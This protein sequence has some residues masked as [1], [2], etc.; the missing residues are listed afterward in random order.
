MQCMTLDGYDDFFDLA[1]RFLL[2]VLL[3]HF[4]LRLLK[5]LPPNPPSPQQVCV[6]GILQTLLFLYSSS[7]RLIPWHCYWF[8]ATLVIDPFATTYCKDINLFIMIEDIL[9]IGFQYVHIVACGNYFNDVT[10]CELVLDCDALLYNV[11]FLSIQCFKL[12]LA[13]FPLSWCKIVSYKWAS[14]IVTDMTT[15]IIKFWSIQAIG[16]SACLGH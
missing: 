9:E 4:L 14:S 2:V 5:H 1:L 15:G 16:T 12:Q 11:K 7:L 10:D 3:Y 8:L 6:L 13:F